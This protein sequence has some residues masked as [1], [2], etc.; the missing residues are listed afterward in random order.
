MYVSKTKFERNSSLENYMCITWPVLEKQNMQ[1]KE[2]F[3]QTYKQIFFSM[4]FENMFTL[5]GGYAY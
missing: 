2:V 1:D 3:W 4:E 5:D